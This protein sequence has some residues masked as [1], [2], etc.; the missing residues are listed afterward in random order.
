MS[1][2]TLEYKELN[3]SKLKIG[4][5]VARWNN[6]VTTGLLLG[7]LQALTECKVAEKNIRVIDVVG[8]YELPYAAKVM[9]ESKKK[10]DAIITLGCLIKGETMHFEYIASAVAQGI[11]ELNVD[12]KV[13]VVFGVLT[14]FNQKQAKARAKGK[15][16]HGYGWGMTAVEMALLKTKI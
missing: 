5:V 11:M 12:E 6:D 10:F 8:S 4:I 2:D 9:M 16:N 15:N 14:C 3:G 7:A 1:H 13:P